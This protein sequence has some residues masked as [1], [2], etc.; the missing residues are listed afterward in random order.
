MITSLNGMMYVFQKIKEALIL[1]ES[2][3]GIGY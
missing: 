3:K 1:K 2:N